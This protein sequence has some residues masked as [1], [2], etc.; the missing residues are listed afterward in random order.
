MDL[1]TLEM[2]LSLVLRLGDMVL[3][4]GFLIIQL[5]FAHPQDFMGG[6]QNIMEVFM[7]RL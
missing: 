6:R 2:R 3:S 4:A 1:H 7:I 5:V